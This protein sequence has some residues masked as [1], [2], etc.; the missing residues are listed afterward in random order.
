[1]IDESKLQGKAGA[2]RFAGSG[3][4]TDRVLLDVAAQYDTQLKPK[5]LTVAAKD[6]AKRFT[7]EEKLLETTKYDGEGVF[8]Y[9]E[10]GNKVAEI[11]AFS[12]PSGRVR[13]GLGAL[14]ALATQLKRQKVKKT[15]LRAELYLPGSVD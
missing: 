4:V 11:F 5:F 10:G 7:G 8:I 1:M 6:I 12:A 9:Y 13:L 14:D 3:A 2:Y 15:L